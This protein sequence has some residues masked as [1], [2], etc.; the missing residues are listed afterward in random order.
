VWRVPCSS[1]I[2]KKWHH[3]GF[4]HLNY[5]SKSSKWWRNGLIFIWTMGTGS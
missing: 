1:T 2:A 4:I 3:L 5:G